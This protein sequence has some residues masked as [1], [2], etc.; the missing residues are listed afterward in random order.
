MKYPLEVS[1]TSINKFDRTDMVEIKE[2]KK[3]W[4]YIR[5]YAT[6]WFYFDGRKFSNKDKDFNVDFF[7]LYVTCPQVRVFVK[8]EDYL[9]LKF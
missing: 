9:M 5:V 8:K 7:K 2:V 6:I 4:K 1:R 3:R